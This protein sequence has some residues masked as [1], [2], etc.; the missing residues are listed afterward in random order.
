M[1]LTPH[2]SQVLEYLTHTP[3][4]L[5]ATLIHAALPH[6]NLVTIYR[7]LDY[8]VENQAVKKVHLSGD[9]SLFEVQHEPHHHAVCS[10][11][12]KIIHFTT[13][14]TSLIKEFSIPGF[15]IH[16]LE[17]TIHGQCKSHKVLHKKQ[18]TKT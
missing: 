9:E 7:I 1:R 18:G 14:D 16:S 2:R 17:V 13:N 10:V 15:V 12:G 3:R 8:L 6:I 4:A 5:S 11:C